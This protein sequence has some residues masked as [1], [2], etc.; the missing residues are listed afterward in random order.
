MGNL[1]EN[2]R[3]AWPFRKNPLPEE[4][5]PGLDAAQAGNPA[6]AQKPADISPQGYIYTERS[7]S[8]IEFDFTTGQF[9]QTPLGKNVKS[10]SEDFLSRHPQFPKSTGHVATVLSLKYGV[11]SSAPIRE[12][13][14]SG[15]LAGVETYRAGQ[16]FG[17]RFQFPHVLICGLTFLHLEEGYTLLETSKRL[18]QMLEG[19]FL[20]PFLRNLNEDYDQGN[21]RS[22]AKYFS[23]KALWKEFPLES[24]SERQGSAPVN[25]T[26]G[27]LN[28]TGVPDADRIAYALH[29]NSVEDVD[30]L[31]DR[32]NGQENSRPAVPIVDLEG[33][34]S[35]ASADSHRMRDVLDK[36]PR[37]YETFNRV[38]LNIPV[39]LARIIVFMALAQKKQLRIYPDL[40]EN[41]SFYD[42]R[43]GLEVCLH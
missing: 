35:Y 25:K 36:T 21:L 24:A 19:T 31:T 28:A 23:D 6:I 40:S 39:A 2:L 8:L 34:G 41:A 16:N 29:P 5:K 32:Q 10:F 12:F 38:R 37:S 18:P 15:V 20:Q 3:R 7:V 17:Y 9:W 42:L 27:S 4:L 30:F 11:A 26:K 1:G 14:K 33:L 13:V 43:T 22:G